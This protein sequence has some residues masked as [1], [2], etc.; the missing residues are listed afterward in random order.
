MVT[1]CGASNDTKGGS[2]A[3][4]ACSHVIIRNEAWT[5]QL[6]ADLD[7][8]RWGEMLATCSCKAAT[9]WEEFDLGGAWLLYGNG[10]AKGNARTYLEMTGYLG[11]KCR[12]QRNNMQKVLDG[13]LWQ[14]SRLVVQ[15]L[16][17]AIALVDEGDYTH[18][19]NCQCLK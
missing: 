17:D 9:A 6:A 4:Q 12:D 8:Y 2:C 10:D 14:C 13:G 5:G 1:T 15:L 19:P 3:A 18:P 16:V 7:R 11:Q